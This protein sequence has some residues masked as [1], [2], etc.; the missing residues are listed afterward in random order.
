MRFSGITN[1]NSDPLYRVKTCSNFHNRIYTNSVNY[2][3]KLIGMCRSIAFSIGLI[4][5]GWS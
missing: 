5:R 3:L 4:E 2:Y 1:N